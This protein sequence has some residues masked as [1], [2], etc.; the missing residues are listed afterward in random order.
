[1][2]HFERRIIEFHH[3]G[4]QLANT[5]WEPTPFEI[6]ADEMGEVVFAEVFPPATGAGD[7][8]ILE[9]W[10]PVLDGSKYDDYLALNGTRSSSM[11]P[12]EINTLGNIVAFGTPVCEAVHKAVPML[13]ARCP[14]FK[15]KVSVE[16]WAGTGAISANY[17][18]RLHCYIYRKEELAAIATVIPGLASLRDIARRRTIPVGKGAIALNYDNWDKLPGGLMQSVPKINPFIIWAQNKADTTPNVD[19]S[20][21]AVLA[22]IDTAKPWQELYFDYE[23]GEDILIVNGLGV[24]VPS[25]SNIKDVCLVINGDDHPRYRIPIDMTSLGTSGDQANNPLHFGHLFPFISTGVRLWKPIPKF[26]R[27]H[28][29]D[30]EIAEVVIRDNGVAVPADDIMLALSG[31]K[32][33][34][35]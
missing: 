4:D 12:P 2:K 10:Y 31:V 1:M 3:T 21:R 28:I 34:R 29:V 33:E 30:R 6:E 5:P 7:E 27:P 15:S 22:T 9:R 13:E 11:N 17:R 8:E 23:D 20:F 26:D 24:R 25:D 18:I 32:I 19:Y 35:I 14:K 16:A